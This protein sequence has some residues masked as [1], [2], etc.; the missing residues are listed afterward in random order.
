MI[1]QDVALL[2]AVYAAWNEGDIDGMLQRIDPDIEW[3]PG[4][5]SP[6]PGMHAGRAGF[7][8][9][10]RSWADMFERVHIDLGEI[11]SAGDWLMSEQRQRSRLPDSAADLEAVVTH[12]WRVRDGKIDR[13]F[14]FRDEDEACAFL[15]LDA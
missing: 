3:R 10:V 8:R 1:S 2:E 12:V 7:E 13:W 4:T 15:G 6:F 5:D 9:Y 14:S 11:R